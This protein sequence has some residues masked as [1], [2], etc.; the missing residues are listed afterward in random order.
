MLDN[1]DVESATTLEVQ[2]AVCTGF[3]IFE[4]EL[5]VLYGFNRL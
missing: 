3:E 5:K 4:A 1:S 2:A